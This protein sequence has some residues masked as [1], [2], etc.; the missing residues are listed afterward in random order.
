MQLGVGL[1]LAPVVFAVTTGRHWVW[2]VSVVWYAVTIGAIVAMS[3]TSTVLERTDESVT[4]RLTRRPWE[5][6]Q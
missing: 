3:W 1:V 2:Y 4:Y 6:F 5:G